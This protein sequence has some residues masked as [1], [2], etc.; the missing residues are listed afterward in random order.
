MSDQGELRQG[1]ITLRGRRLALIGVW[2]NLGLA[3]GKLVVGVVGHSYALIADAIESFVDVAGSAVVWVGMKVAAK[4]PDE[5]HPYGH[6]RA[7]S[8]AALAVAIII[9]LAGIGIAIEAVREILTP[10]HA[11]AWYTLVALVAVVVI[12]ELMARW[13]AREA[14]REGSV[15]LS[16]ESFHHRAD[17]LTSIFAFI[18]ISIALIGGKGWE[19]ADDWAALAASGVILFN[20]ARLGFEPLNDLLDVDH[21]VLTDQAAK[22]AASV[23]GVK[24]VDKPRTRRSGAYYWIDMHVRVDDDMTVRQGHDIAHKVK[25]AVRRELP[26]VRD[27][28]VHLEPSRR[29][30]D[31]QPL[32][33]AAT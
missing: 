3:L 30:D 23:E 14:K 9:F 11:P 27:V 32:A 17:V 8:L 1:G 20:A 19:P 13:A 26:Q 24:S 16:A 15:A 7:E 4:P 5:D 22:I 12:K 25:D 28:L 2:V 10:H 33:N 31:Q 18:G 21:S 29:P 6:G